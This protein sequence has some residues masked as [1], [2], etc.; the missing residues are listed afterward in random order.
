VGQDIASQPVFAVDRRG[1]IPGKP[2]T[3]ESPAPSVPQMAVFRTLQVWNDHKS[4]HPALFFVPD[5]T[6][7][8][9]VPPREFDFADAELAHIRLALEAWV[10]YGV[11]A[12]RRWLEPLL[13]SMR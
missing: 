8:P 9:S 5:K 4:V 10:D 1:A 12:D 13:T 7:G 2:R 11:T 3:L 6:V